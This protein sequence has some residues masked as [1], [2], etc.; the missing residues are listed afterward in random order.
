MTRKAIVPITVLVLG[1]ISIAVS[2]VMAQT[3]PSPALQD[4]LNHHHRRLYAL[5]K[6]MTAEMAK[7]TEAM[8]RDLTPEQ[9]AEMAKRMEAMSSL[10]HRMSGI[11]AMPAMGDVES[12]GQMNQ[13]RKQMDEMMNAPAMKPGSK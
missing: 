7:M 10:M 3:A 9:R 1:L 12:Q 8:S 5:M 2:P 13:M 6:D 4:L 11:E